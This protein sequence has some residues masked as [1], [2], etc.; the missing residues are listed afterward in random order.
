VPALPD[1]LQGRAFIEQLRDVR[2]DDLLGRGSN[3][4]GAKTDELH[5]HLRGRR[6]L[7]TGAA[8]SIGCELARQIAACDPALVVLFDRN[9]SELYFTAVE[10]R[11]RFPTSTIEARVGDITDEPFVRRLMS[12]FE[13]E[14][15]Y[16]A[17][18]YKHVPL[19]EA[20]PLEAIKNNVFGT[21]TIATAASQAGVEQ[22]VNVSTDK[23]VQPVSVMGMTKRAA[24]CVV[25]SLA[26]RGTTFVSV[27]FGNVLGSH[28][29]VL[30]LFH[31]QVA[32]GSPL[33]IT[34]PD[35]TRY[36]MLVS[37]AVE[38]VLQAGRVGHDGDIYVLDMG[39][40]IRIGDL[41][42]NLVRLAGLE[43]QIDVPIEVVGLR[44][45]ERLHEHAGIGAD[46]EATPGEH[47]HILVVRGPELDQ[48]AFHSHMN[49]LRE[50]A[51]ASD[52]A[53]SLEALRSL[54]G[55]TERLNAAVHVMEDG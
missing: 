17:A 44:P 33:T 47:K 25:A 7:V 36:F 9:E 8:G 21:E 6:V 48:Q 3:G 30:P 40:P 23:A 39:E 11:E 2:L 4:N 14:L 16:H 26:G 22:F 51:I 52:A 46:E 27:R 10:L 54:V 41:A 28:G 38:L 43:P 18:A 55:A 42:E 53:G 20:Q 13:P 49:E 34:D 15:V 24:E 50:R 5:R 1:L 37:E 32:R 12:E 31:R 35:A 45:G 29:S 19:M